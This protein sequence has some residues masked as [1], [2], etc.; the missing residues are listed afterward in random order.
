M[1]A[2]IAAFGLVVAGCS[3]KETAQASSDGKNGTQFTLVPSNFTPANYTKIDLFDAV[4][5]IENPMSVETAMGFIANPEALLNPATMFSEAFPRYVSDLVLVSQSGTTIYFKTA[6]NAISKGFIIS[7]RSGL[8]VGQKA[9]VYYSIQRDFD[10]P[11]LSVW[12]VDA[13]EKF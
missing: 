11:M 5:K 12:T 6:D 13:I 10:Y 7:S 8:T 9:R 4:A 2:L 1:L 3:K